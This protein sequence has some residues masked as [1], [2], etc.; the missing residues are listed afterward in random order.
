[1]VPAI[2]LPAVDQR[3]LVV[4]LLPTLQAA[5]RL[6]IVFGPG[7]FLLAAGLVVHSISLDLVVQGFI[8]FA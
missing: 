4:V 8:K 1:M 6:E 2:A 5:V 3:P 7:G